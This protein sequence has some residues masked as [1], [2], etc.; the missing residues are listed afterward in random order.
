MSTLLDKRASRLLRHGVVGLALL[1]QV[2]A[3]FGATRGLI[4]CIQASGHVAVEDYAAMARC[5]APAGALAT[6]AVGD[7]SVRGAP[8]RCVDTQLLEDIREGSAAPRQSGAVPVA[9]AASG[10]L[11]LHD[12]FAGRAIRLREPPPAKPARVLRSI[13]LLI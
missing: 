9:L 6:H 5:H 12:A 11:G 3:T 8:E 10:G 13:V 1:L 4:L 7:V 2:V